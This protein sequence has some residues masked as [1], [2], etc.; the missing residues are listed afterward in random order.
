MGKY[1]G[2]DWENSALITID[3]QHDFTLPGA[4][5]GVAGTMHVV[6]AVGSPAGAFRGAGRRII[7]VVSL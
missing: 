1:T 4:P 3:V 2:P 7:H 6:P 5:S